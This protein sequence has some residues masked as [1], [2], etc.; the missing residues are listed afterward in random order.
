MKKFLLAASV[1]MLTFFLPCCNDA[2]DDPDYSDSI[3]T[4]IS[5]EPMPFCSVPAPDANQV[6]HDDNATF[7]FSNHPKNVDAKGTFYN[8][9]VL[10]SY[11]VYYRFPAGT[12]TDFSFSQNISV[13]VASGGTAQFDTVVVRASDKMDGDFTSGVDVDATVY[14]YGKDVSGEDV[15]TS[16]MFTINFRDICGGTTFGCDGI[17]NDTDGSIDEETLCDGLDDDGDGSVDEDP[18]CV[19]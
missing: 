10:N 14:F 9:V 12:G 4:I 5:V 18:C 8:D 7:T 17:D 3:V 15:Q 19:F 16:V 1:L 13:R 2:T 6:Y 11:T